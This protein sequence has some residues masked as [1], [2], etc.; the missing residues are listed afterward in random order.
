[1]ILVEK[2][3]VAIWKQRRIISAET[4]TITLNRQEPQLFSS[5]NL[6]LAK[7]YT[8]DELKP[9]DLEPVDSEH[10]LWSQSVLEEWE[11]LVHE[12]DQE[13]SLVELKEH[14][15]ERWQELQDEAQAAEL[16]VEAYL[17]DGG[18]DCY[19][20]F[21][22]AKK[23]ADLILTKSRLQPKVVELY[24]AASAELSILPDKPRASFE[25]YQATLDNQLYRAIKELRL[26]QDRRISM[27]EAI[28]PTAS[29]ETSG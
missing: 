2:I 11:N 4:A 14:A 23:S 8:R 5:V 6:A 18:M 16:S 20:W 10:V 22:E 7:K 13:I 28:Q 9:T 25:R 12:E 29:E 26:L 24:Q 1:M 21:Y 27:I 19:D 15:P 17:K 3:A